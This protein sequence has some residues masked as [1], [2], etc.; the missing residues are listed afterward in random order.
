MLFIFCHSRF[1]PLM[2]LSPPIISLSK[3]NTFNKNKNK[4]QFNN[5]NFAIVAELFSLKVLASTVLKHVEVV[6]C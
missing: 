5:N 4:Q 6:A 3:N 2:A 1:C